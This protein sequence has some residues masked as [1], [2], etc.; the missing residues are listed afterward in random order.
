MDRKPDVQT[1]FDLL[2]ISI[3]LYPGYKRRIKMKKISLNMKLTCMLIFMLAVPGIVSFL[4]IMGMKQ[5]N[6]KLNNIV[7]VSSQKVKLASKISQDILEM[8]RTE[9][10]IILSR[11]Q[12]KVDDHLIF[13][14]KLE[15]EMQENKQKL[16]DLVDDDGKANLD[17]FTE[18]WNE[19]L[20]IKEEIHRLT[21][22]DPAS[23][24]QGIRL[25]S[26]DARKILD[27]TLVIIG[28]I[29]AENEKGM[30]RDKVETDAAYRSG[31]N[32]MLGFSA[33][34]F[35]LAFIFGLYLI[36]SI[37][38]PFKEVFSGLNHFSEAEL[39]E[40]AD[41]FRNIIANLSGSQ[42]AASSQSLS[43]GASEQ[44]ASIEETTSSLEE[45]SSMIKQNA[46]N[47]GLANKLMKEAIQIVESANVS[48][49][50]LTGSMGEICSAS[51]NISEIIRTIDSIAFQTNLLA[52]NAAV[53]AARAGN[54]GA[55]FAVVAGEVRNLA[56]R[57]ADAAK[58]ISGMI[59]N[60]IRKVNE[61]SQLVEKTNDVFKQVAQ[62]AVRVGELVAE[63]AAGSGD[64]SV[65]IEQVTKAMGE[66]DT[67]VQQNAAN[68]EQL[69]AQAEQM[70]GIVDELMAITAGSAR[71]KNRSKPYYSGD[72]YNIRDIFKKVPEKTE[73]KPSKPRAKKVKPEHLIPLDEDDF[74]DF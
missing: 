65:G 19:Y 31:R 7:D 62:S 35:G 36:R 41:K 32:R 42:V 61:G 68:A 56:M 22:L 2:I 29:I 30:E 10:N 5:I 53:E 66:M 17:K 50:E 58:N 11:D 3:P 12:E 51:G 59:E 34:G 8:A 37:T 67:V 40:T 60:I 52:L 33:A 15:T 25:S 13:I 44:A 9:K 4:G 46:K 69:S 47:A 23:K 54:A 39:N 21:A 49:N 20:A 24:L 63:I 16:Y 55:G 28:D 1:F 18:K 26:N 64:Q 74:T 70:D 73:H 57:S 43:G 6:Q 71:K 48:M 72:K 45:V 38:R 14:K 27:Q